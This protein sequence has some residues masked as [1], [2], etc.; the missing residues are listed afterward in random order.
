MKLVMK[1]EKGD[2]HVM[3]LKVL[4]MHRSLFYAS[5]FILARHFL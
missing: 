4:D 5:S 3:T 2:D 1:G